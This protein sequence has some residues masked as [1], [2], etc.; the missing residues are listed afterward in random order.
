MSYIMGLKE[1]FSKK[2]KSEKS[3]TDN[4]KNELG[5]DYDEGKKQVVGQAHRMKK[6]W[7]S[8]EI[9]QLK[10]DAIAVLFKKKRYEDK[11]FEEFEKITKEGYHMMLMESVKAIDAGPID[12]QI[13]N[14]YYFQHK[15]Y[16]K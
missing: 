15:N 10:T 9:V 5:S 1:K 14:F 8:K 3:S 7:K 6:L 4:I 13:G 12:I 16:I 11:F 2:G